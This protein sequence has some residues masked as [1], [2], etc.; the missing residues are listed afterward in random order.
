MGYSY[1]EEQLFLKDS[2]RKYFLDNYHYE[3]I[4][5]QIRAG[6]DSSKET[7]QALITM[8]V[9]SLASDAQ[10][11]GFGD[12]P[13]FML[14]FL[15]ESGYSRLLEPF[16]FNVFAP[17]T[18][19]NSADNR[20]LATDMQ[21]MLAQG[22]LRIAM[23]WEEAFSGIDQAQQITRAK[24]RSDQW[25]LNGEKSS[26]LGA[27]HCDGLIITALDEE[28]KLT[29]FM[30]SP[31]SAGVHLTHA[32]LA[33][34]GSISQLQLTD[35][36]V[37]TD[38]R[39]F[40]GDATPA[41]TR[42]LG[43]T[44]LGLAAEALGIC[45]RLLQLTADHCK[46]RQQFGQP[47]AAFQAVQHRLADMYIRQQKLIS[48]Y[49]GA[50]QALNTNEAPAMAA[51]VKAELGQSCVGIAQDAIQLFGGIGMTDELSVGLY[52]KRAITISLIM[53]QREQHLA[54]LGQQL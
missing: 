42:A 51:M 37:D 45:E 17:A 11:G 34:G 6:A 28:D 21:A 30:V 19:L 33:D 32:Q 48:M 18:V 3:F 25:L 38:Q 13:L 22:E 54:W 9:G 50:V 12:D 52:L 40:S 15:E 47:L 31:D 29:A 4:R 1:N 41:I 5:E 8:G 46:T 24:Q 23:A 14:A 10:T 35:V 53:G 36:A 43:L 2:L 27:R 49:W 44:Q 7:W 20:Q 39:L 26:V 16:L